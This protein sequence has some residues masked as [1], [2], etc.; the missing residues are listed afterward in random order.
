M[1]VFVRTSAAVLAFFAGGAAFPDEPE[2]EEE[3]A[4]VRWPLSLCCEK[5]TSN[6]DRR[7]TKK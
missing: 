2:E 5:R 3:A 1:L 6:S 4:L 7:G